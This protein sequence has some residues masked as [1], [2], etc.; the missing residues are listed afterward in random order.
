MIKATPTPATTGQCARERSQIGPNAPDS[1]A[2]TLPGGGTSTGVDFADGIAEVAGFTLTAAETGITV[3]AALDADQ[4]ATFDDPVGTTPSATLTVDPGADA[5]YRV[6][7]ASG[8]PTAGAN[9]QLT[10]SLVDQF[11]NVT[12]GFSGDKSLTFSGLANAPDGTVPTVT[13]K[14]GGAGATDFGTATIITLTSGVSS[15]GGLL[16]AFKAEIC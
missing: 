6:V 8:T 16:I 14:S 5:A 7:A 4:N 9:N 1:T 15:D 12:T 10:I 11:Q 13:T 2:P 3:S